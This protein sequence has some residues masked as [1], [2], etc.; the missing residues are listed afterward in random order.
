MVIWRKPKDDEEIVV[1]GECDCGAF[2]ER[3]T[4]NTKIVKRETHEGE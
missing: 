4:C 2:V 1:T 3:C